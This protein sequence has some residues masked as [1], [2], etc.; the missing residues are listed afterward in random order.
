MSAL[1]RKIKTDQTLRAKQPAFHILSAT[2]LTCE[3]MSVSAI[4]SRGAP[5]YGNAFESDTNVVV[6]LIIFAI[7]LRFTVL[8]KKKVV[9]DEEEETIE[10]QSG[11]FP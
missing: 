9:E 5:S 6:C 4:V 2:P 7:C 8:K 3:L 11:H 1:G 10:E